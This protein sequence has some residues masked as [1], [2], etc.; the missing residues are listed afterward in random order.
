[1]RRCFVTAAL[2]IGTLNLGCC[3]WWCE[4]HCPCEGSAQ[5]CGAP[6][7]GYAGNGCCC[8]TTTAYQPPVAAPA[9]NFN[10]PRPVHCDCYP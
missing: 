4:R 10:Q 5:S 6:P 9:Q 2:L 8:P 1:M 7:A 3:S